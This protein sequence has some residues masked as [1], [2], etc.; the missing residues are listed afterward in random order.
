MA[1]N[2]YELTTLKDIFDKVP[3]AKIMLC[4]EELAK[5]MTQAKATLELMCS[6]A[7]S[8]EGELTMVDVKW[9]DSV[10][11]VDDDK[12]IVGCDFVT[13]SGDP[14]LS[15]RVTKEADE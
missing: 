3:T 4:M 5:G 9:P 13:Q 2:E 14:L 6:V 8:M 15:V 11:W 7:D 10:T 1:D 12:G